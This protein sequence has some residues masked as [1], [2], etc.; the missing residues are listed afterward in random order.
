MSLIIVKVDREKHTQ[1]VY[2]DGITLFGDEILTNNSKKVGHFTYNGICV[3]YGNTGSSYFN[4]YVTQHFADVFASHIKDKKHEIT[5]KFYIQELPLMFNEMR[6]NFI[7]E[8]NIPDGDLEITGE[9]G[10][11]VVIDGEIYSVNQYKGENFRTKHYNGHNSFA[12]G[13]GDESAKCLLDT[14]LSIQEIYDIISRHYSTV[15]NNVFCE[16]NSIYLTE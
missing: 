11:L 3:S 1:S 6:T 7:A 14:Q 12:C 15:N 8:Y 2:S 4:Q 13:V 16:E 5:D 10:S 9:K